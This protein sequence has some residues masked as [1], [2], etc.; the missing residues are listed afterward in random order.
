MRDP[1]SK[2][3]VENFGGQ[4]LLTRNVRLA[5]AEPGHLHRRGTRTCARRSS[6]KRS[7][8]SRA[9]S[10]EDRSV[11]D[12]LTAELHV[13]ERAAGEALRHPGVYG[14]HFRRVTLPDGSPR[15]GLLGQG[16][17]LMVTSYADRTSPVLRGKWL[18]ENLLG[19]PPPPPPPDVPPLDES[20]RRARA[21]CHDARAHGA[22]PRQPA[23]AACHAR[24]DPLGF[25][26]EN[27]DA[28]GGWRTAEGNKPI[29]ASGAMPD[30]T[31]FAG[32]ADLQSAPVAAATSSWRPW[33][34]S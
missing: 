14:G 30:G 16:S 23:C 26:L 24:M 10:R 8:S 1:R 9:C 17:I 25:A 19:T 11:L 33:P 32:P 22:A 12:L 6:R 7:S 20:T 31:K 2:A 13:P 21:E 4:W 34:R 5:H 29:D 18:L 28:I 3:L 27:F 15:G